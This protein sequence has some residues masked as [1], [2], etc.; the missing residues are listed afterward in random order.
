MNILITGV[1]GVG[2]TTVLSR[3]AERLGNSVSGFITEEV[4]EDAHRIGFD[5]VSFDGRRGILAR[6]GFK[7]PHRVGSY[8][9]E[10][11]SFEN[12]ALPAIELAAEKVLIIDE[13]GKMELF[14][15]RFRDAVLLALDSEQTVVAAIMRK[16]HPFANA[17][18]R[19]PD[20]RLI[21]VTRTNRDSLPERLVELCGE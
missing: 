21:E 18:K 3:L 19:R 14:S 5:I 4:C 8:G 12:I 15:Q 6:K 16:S 2:K 11:Q 17:I 13:I 9:V 20:C 1:P 10:L 7:S